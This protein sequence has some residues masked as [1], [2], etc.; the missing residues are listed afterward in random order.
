MAL[1]RFWLGAGDTSRSDDH[2]TA[3]MYVLSRVVS[4]L[5]RISVSRV[6]TLPWTQVAERA[7]NTTISSHKQPNFA[8][9]I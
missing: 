1:V 2:S 7:Y 5:I 4:R 6:A 9:I 8:P 3:H